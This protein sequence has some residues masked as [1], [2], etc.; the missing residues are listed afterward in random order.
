MN[1]E[2]YKNNKINMQNI[3]IN[4]ICIFLVLIFALQL[5]D[6]AKA[7]NNINFLSY[8]DLYG[9]SRFLA[10]SESTNQTDHNDYNIMGHQNK[11]MNVLLGWSIASIAVGTPLAFQKSIVLRDIGIQNIAWGAIDGAIAIFGKNS[12]NNKIEKGYSAEKEKKSFY[13]ILL[14]NTLLDIVYV[15]V[16]TAIVASGKQK[17]KGHGYGVIVQGAFLFIFD[18]INLLLIP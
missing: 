7:F 12:A 3:L 16:G 5:A 14:V 18:G 10:N 9:E 2:N 4:A 15:G 11:A 17:L 6:S 13:R 1:I 8:I